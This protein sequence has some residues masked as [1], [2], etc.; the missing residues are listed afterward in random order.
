MK[1]IT[2]TLLGLTLSST[3]IGQ[4]EQSQNL[5]PIKM[6]PNENEVRSIYELPTKTD[7]ELFNSKGQLIAEGNAKFVDYTE[8]KA[9]IFFIRFNNTTKKIIKE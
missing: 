2:I 8:Y 4:N 9:G 1:L 6:L 5:P 3:A 7:Y